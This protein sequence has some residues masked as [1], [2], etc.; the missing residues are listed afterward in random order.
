MTALAMDVTLPP[1]PV[2]FL[3]DAVAGLTSKPKRL[4]SKYFYDQRGSM[5]FERICE[6]DEY[7]LT[8]HFSRLFIGLLVNDFILMVLCGSYPYIWRISLLSRYSLVMNCHIFQAVT[9]H[10]YEQYN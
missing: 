7:Y 8:R 3:D 1:T 6:L 2:R 4:P 10:D 5:L 9:G